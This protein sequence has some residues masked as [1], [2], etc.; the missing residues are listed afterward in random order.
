MKGSIIVVTKGDT[1]SLD[2]SCIAHILG[3]YSLLAGVTT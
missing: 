3:D 2:C 1:R